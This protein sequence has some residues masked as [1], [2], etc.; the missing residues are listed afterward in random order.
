[1]AYFGQDSDN[2]NILDYFS[3]HEPGSIDIGY[4]SSKM[5][6]FQHDGLL[7]CNYMNLIRIKS[8]QNI[9]KENYFPKI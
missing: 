6:S 2:V 5:D 7:V 3:N 9:L 8:R 4:K 1:M